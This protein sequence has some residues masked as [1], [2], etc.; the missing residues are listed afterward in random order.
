MK[1]PHNDEKVLYMGR[2]EA[3]E[4]KTGLYFAGS[5]AIVKIRGTGLSVTINNTCYCHGNFL[6]VVVDGEMREVPLSADD[7]G[8]DITA[9]AVENLSDGE[10][11]VIIY[12]R[13][14]AAQLLF[15]KEF[16]TDGEFLSPDPLPARKLEVYGDS[17]CA[18]E[19]IEAYDY[20]GK[21]DPERPYGQYD[22]V[23]NS[24]VMQTARSL[25][26]QIHNICQGGIALLDGTGYFDPPT[27]R[28]V[29]SI[30]DKVNY[31][32]MHGE[33][34]QWDFSRYVP[35]IVIIAIGQNDCHNGLTD[36]NDICI[37]DPGYRTVWKT[38][39]IKLVNELDRHYGG[40][41]FVLTTTVL[42]HDP[43]WDNAIEEIKSE[44]CGMGIKAYH[45]MFSRNGAATPGHPR[46]AEHNEMARELT[47]FIEE[48]VL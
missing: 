1:I 26:A 7:N 44:L 22:N 48:N 46:L 24:F 35:D 10:H 17:V 39:Y 20:V 6:G 45:N 29:E 36:K 19:V 3:A 18:G 43:D 9:A 14:A 16:E 34:T 28:G 38:G 42:M 47:R 32:V 37:Q 11:T 21:H 5:Q 2:T 30:Y 31:S 15:I 27:Y 25:N 41:K 13:Y 40:V 33:P 12:K 8:K 23:W 4:D